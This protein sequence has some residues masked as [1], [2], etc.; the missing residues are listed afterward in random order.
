MFN[1]KNIKNHGNLSYMHA[2][3]DYMTVQNTSHILMFSSVNNYSLQ[4]M[5][6]KSVAYIYYYTLFYG[7]SEGYI[8]MTRKLINGTSVEL[9]QFDIDANRFIV[10]SF[11]TNSN[12]TCM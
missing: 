5:I 1:I 3:G 6:K 9:T 10:N 12:S 2:F 11:V 4:Y 7:K 8:F